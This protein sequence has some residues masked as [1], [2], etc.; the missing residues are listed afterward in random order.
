MTLS[1]FELV[2]LLNLSPEDY[3]E[4]VALVPSL[5]QKISERNVEEILDV[6][7][8]STGRSAFQGWLMPAHTMKAETLR[9]D[10][11]NRLCYGCKTIA[12]IA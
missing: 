11:D 10:M 9:I 7:S 1:D 5:H 4:A 6:I 2:S 8:N 3:D 12:N